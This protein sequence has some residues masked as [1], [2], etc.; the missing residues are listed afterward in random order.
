[1]GEVVVDTASWHSRQF[2]GKNTTGRQVRN[3][4]ARKLNIKNSSK[5]LSQQATQIP[6][7]KQRGLGHSGPAISLLPVILLVN[8]TFLPI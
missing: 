4:E 6:T 1:M 8:W 3:Y 7:Q 2:V 5:A